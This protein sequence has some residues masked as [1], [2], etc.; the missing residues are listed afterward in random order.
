[1]GLI[2]SLDVYPA[3]KKAIWQEID[4]AVLRRFHAK[5][6]SRSLFR[7]AYKLSC[8]DIVPYL[9]AEFSDLAGGRFSF[10]GALGA[11]ASPSSS[12]V[13]AAEL[14]CPDHGEV[15]LVDGSELVTEQCLVCLELGWHTPPKQLVLQA[16]RNGQHQ[17][18]LDTLGVTESEGHHLLNFEL[19]E[20]F[21]V[22][23]S[24]GDYHPVVQKV[25]PLV[26]TAIDG[27]VSRMAA[28]VCAKSA[29]CTSART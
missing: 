23:I 2:T 13:Y 3:L 21:G 11:G 16:L 25:K 7:R 6:L 19:I 12:T 17:S 28:I 22:S 18:I 8:G 1:M 10:L 9:V 14:T 29:Q 20:A 26:N 27:P 4:A 5:P 15:C 24:E